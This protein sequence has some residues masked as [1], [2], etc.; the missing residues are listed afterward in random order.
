MIPPNRR[1]AL[2]YPLALRTCSLLTALPPDSID[3]T[4]SIA[5]FGQEEQSCV[6]KLMFDQVQ[7][8]KGLPSSDDLVREL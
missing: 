8:Q 2:P 4:R 7:K 1:R 3:T 5:D 6:Q